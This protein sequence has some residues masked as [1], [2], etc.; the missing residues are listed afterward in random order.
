MKTPEMTLRDYFAGLAMQTM[1]AAAFERFETD[2]GDDL[3]IIPM[4]AYG[5]AEQMIEERIDRDGEEEEE[6]EFYPPPKIGQ[7]WHKQGGI[8]FGRIEENGKIYALIVA[9]KEEGEKT[10]VTWNEAMQF[11]RELRDDLF[12]DWEMP[13]RYDLMTIFRND[14]EHTGEFGNEWYWSSTEFNSTLAWLQNFGN[15]SQCNYSKTYTYSV[16]AVRK[17]L[18]SQFNY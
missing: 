13:T 4:F 14:S 17:V 18:I 6:K 16:R 5:M 12:D 15:G 7:Y 10:G 1:M 9:R 11:C 2:G 8:Y 3:A